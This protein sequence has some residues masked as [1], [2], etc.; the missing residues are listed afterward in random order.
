MA[1]NLSGVP[2][3]LGAD[4]HS[5]GGAGWDGVVFAQGSVFCGL[6]NTHCAYW[7]SHSKPQHLSL[8]TAVLLD[9]FLG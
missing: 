9:G 8:Q 1:G 5:R 7:R 4:S 3:G 6:L 2:Q